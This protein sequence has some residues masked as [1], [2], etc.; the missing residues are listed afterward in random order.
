LNT[1]S[2][3]PGCGNNEGIQ[4]A[5]F[6]PV[7]ENELFSM[8]S[9]KESFVEDI[10]KPGSSLNPTFLAILDAA[11][12]CLF[13]VFLVLAFLSSGNI[14][15]FALLGIELCLWASVKWCVLLIH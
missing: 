6:V 7:C 4:E 1:G 5:L 2:S 15:V 12:A 11:F 10:L 14:H 3:G 13:V 9:K 8:T